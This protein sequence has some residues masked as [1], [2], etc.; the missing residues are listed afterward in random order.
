MVRAS[1]IFWTGRNSN[2]KREK[3]ETPW[4]GCRRVSLSTSEAACGIGSLCL[5]D[6]RAQGLSQRDFPP[7]L[8]TSS[9]PSPQ[10]ERADRRCNAEVVPESRAARSLPQIQRDR[11]SAPSGRGAGSR[12]TPNLA[13]TLIHVGGRLAIGMKGGDQLASRHRRTGA[14]LRAFRR[15]LGK[16]GYLAIGAHRRFGATTIEALRPA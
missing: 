9:G 6:G 3:T 1:L 14:R 5:I 8:R 10:S 16:R 11:R 15:A 4:T 2:V 7:A 12:N 13:L